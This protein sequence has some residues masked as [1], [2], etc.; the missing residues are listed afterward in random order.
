M[1]DKKAQATWNW[2]NNKKA[3]PC[4]FVKHFWTILFMTPLCNCNEQMPRWLVASTSK[5]CNN[6]SYINLV[7]ESCFLQNRLF[8][9]FFYLLIRINLLDR[10]FVAP[11]N[12]TMPVSLKALAQI[13]LAGP[14][15]SDPSQN[16]L[17]S[18][19][20][21]QKPWALQSSLICIHNHNCNQ[22]NITIHAAG[23]E[24]CGRNTCYC[25]VIR[26]TVC[27]FVA[28]V[29]SCVVVWLIGDELD[30]YSW[31]FTDHSLKRYL[32]TPTWV[33]EHHRA[34]IQPAPQHQ[35]AGPER[36][37]EWAEVEVNTSEGVC[38]KILELG[39]T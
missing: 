12:L 1:T 33:E 31:T 11:H 18:A 7:Y 25:F 19:W 24:F 16:Q 36:L 30:P 14:L 9:F 37:C 32:S 23:F 34:S 38:Q 27:T 28:D 20:C 21:T 6:N 39:S 29:E 26:S 8:S 22:R 5:N 3:T 2:N 4:S 15:C 35:P 17:G 13:L 10:T